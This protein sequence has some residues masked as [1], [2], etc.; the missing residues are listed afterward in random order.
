MDNQ[1][2]KEQAHEIAGNTDNSIA[3]WCLYLALLFRSGI[4]STS[5]VRSLIDVAPS[6]FD[7]VVKTAQELAETPLSPPDFLPL[8]QH[9]IFFRDDKAELK[10]LKNEVENLNFSARNLR[11]QSY[12]YAAAG[13]LGGLMIGLFFA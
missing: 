4:D 3:F 9:I 6:D 7:F 2:L 13:A 8:L 10:H 1:E 12:F 11:Q 5:N